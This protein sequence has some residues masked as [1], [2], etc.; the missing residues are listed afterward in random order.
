M[1]EHWQWEANEKAELGNIEKMGKIILDRL[2]R[3]GCVVT[4]MYGI[5]HN[6]DEKTLWN[7][8]KRVYEVAFTSNHAHFVMKLSQ[9]KTLRELADVIGIAPAYIEKP[10]R[11][12]YAY[13]SML[14]YLTHI[15]Y[16]KKYQYAPNA[17]V[18]IIGKPYIEYY[19]QRHESWMQGRDRRSIDFYKAMTEKMKLGIARGEILMADIC[20]NKD[21]EI[22]YLMKPEMFKKILD[23]K[24]QIDRMKPLDEKIRIRQAVV[25]RFALQ[26]PDTRFL[27]EEQEKLEDLAR[28]KARSNFGQMIAGI[29][30]KTVE[31]Q[32]DILNK[33]LE[34][35]KKWKLYDLDRERAEKQLE[36]LKKEQAEM[37]LDRMIDSREGKSLDEQIRIQK[38]IVAYMERWN[39]P[40]FKLFEERKILRDLEN[41]LKAE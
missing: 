3:S 2:Q 34:Y 32:I 6:R 24:E 7:E 18:T 10:K 17:V 21:Y 30:G 9:G 31:A 1:P 14:A 5:V 36:R 11:G 16:E 19:R 29:N 15:K 37:E 41:R 23:E 26:H 25:E 39:M 4:E 13:D 8:N 12:R 22:C 38:E 28:D 40:C 35:A 20:N 27:A 33:A